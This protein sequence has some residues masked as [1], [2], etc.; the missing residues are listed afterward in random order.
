MKGTI[1]DHALDD[2]KNYSLVNEINSVGHI[3]SFIFTGR[4][5]LHV[6]GQNL[7]SIVRKC[8]DIVVENRYKSIPEI[9]NDVSTL[10]GDFRN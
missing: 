7:G 4:Q 5:N 3:I 1:I 10:T 8:T 2:F 9:I 6:S